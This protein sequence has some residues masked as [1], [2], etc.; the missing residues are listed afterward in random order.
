MELRAAI[1]A[2][3]GLRERA[4]FVAI[5]LTL[6]RMHT[7]TTIIPPRTIIVKPTGITMKS[8]ALLSTVVVF[9]AFSPLGCV[10]W[11]EGAGWDEGRGTKVFANRNIVLYT[12]SKIIVHQC[13]ISVAT[14]SESSLQAPG[15]DVH[16]CAH[17]PQTDTHTHT[18]TIK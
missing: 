17:T 9:V 8:R 18:H 2:R 10:G 7:V 6:I 13:N 14:C 5:L 16:W 12:S 3:L 15:T 11:V 1:A 4:A